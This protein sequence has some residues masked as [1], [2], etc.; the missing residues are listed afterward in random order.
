MK[1]ALLCLATAIAIAGALL[2]LIASVKDISDLNDKLILTRLRGKY[3][4]RDSRRPQP[5]HLFQ[6]GD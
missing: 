5:R 2:V 4:I 3:E 1:R 6:F